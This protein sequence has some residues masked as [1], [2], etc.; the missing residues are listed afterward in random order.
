VL[1]V[2]DDRREA[3]LGLAAGVEEDAAG[4]ERV[5]GPRD[6]D[7]LE[8]REVHGRVL[9]HQLAGVQGGLLGLLLG[10]GVGDPRRLEI[11]Q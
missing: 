11:R 6:A 7:L 1:G 3:R 9:E 2:R 4:P 8:L 5:V 10:V